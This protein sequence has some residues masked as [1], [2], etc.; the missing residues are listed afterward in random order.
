MENERL[1]NQLKAIQ[2][3]I[4]A[5]TEAVQNPLEGIQQ[6]LDPVQEHLSQ[7]LPR[8]QQAAILLQNR[9]DEAELEYP[10][11]A[12]F[13]RDWKGK[14]PLRFKRFLDWFFEV[15]NDD[16]SLGELLEHPFE[17][18]EEDL[19]QAS[20]WLLNKIEFEGARTK[21]EKLGLS[22]EDIEYLETV[23]NTIDAVP[24][25]VKSPALAKEYV[26][27]ITSQLDGFSYEAQAVIL[28]D[29]AR[30]FKQLP[31]GQIWLKPSVWIRKAIEQY[32]AELNQPRKEQKP[33]PQAFGPELV[34]VVRKALE[35]KELLTPNGQ[36][37]G[38]KMQTKA[39]Y[40]VLVK[41]GYVLGM[42]KPEERFTA[43][44]LKNFTGDISG[45]ALRN[46][47]SRGQED[48]EIEF[49]SLIPAKK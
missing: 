39:L 27:G 30:Y 43:W 20:L 44:F 28:E 23:N 12:E 49:L 10:K 32:L 31:E 5:I 22:P 3:R 4:R 13:Y 48:E 14:T 1:E 26:E 34:E 17:I 6:K 47:P 33:T 35:A 16:K 8:L 45:R 19:E 11:I 29:I 7:L 15:K 36:Y 37:I 2:E 18:K 40:N 41:R 9:I 46:P 42:P 38:K 21:L 25:S 24:M